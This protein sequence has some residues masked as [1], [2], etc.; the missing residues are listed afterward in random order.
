MSGLEHACTL[1]EWVR[2]VC[3]DHRVKDW[4]GGAGAGFWRP[5]L[6]LLCDPIRPDW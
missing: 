5:L 3:A 4:A 2:M 1:V 6:L